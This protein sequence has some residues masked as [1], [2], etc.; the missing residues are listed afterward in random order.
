MN[1]KDNKKRQFIIFG[2]C[3]FAALVLC[4][5][6]LVI[7]VSQVEN[8]NKAETAQ[9]EIISRTQLSGET[10]ELSRYISDL[11]EYTHNNKFVKINSYTD[12]YVDDGKIVVTD[13]DGN[14]NSKDK[15]IFVY[16]KNQI[17]GS[18][19]G[20]YGEDF[21]GEFGTVCEDMPKLNFLSHQGVVSD[22]SVG[23]KD[24][25][26]NTV[27]DD[28]GNIT[29]EE[30]YYITFKINGG[31]IADSK[32]SE[33]FGQNNTPD[34]EKFLK[35]ELSSVLKIASSSVECGEFSVCVKADRETDEISQVKI[36]R[37]YN[38]NADVQ[39]LGKLS[40]FGKKNISFEYKVEEVYDYFYAGIS[41]VEDEVTMGSDDEVMLNVNA[42][43][44]DDSEYKVTFTSSDESIATVDE[45]GYVKCQ[46]ESKEPVVIT[47][48][49]EYLGQTF[50]DQC[51]VNIE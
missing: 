3:S 45:M 11:A 4:M 36:T 39:F 5:I 6:T 28:D 9:E 33:S 27:Y 32:G 22:F 14:E 8:G 43:I 49:L 31:E 18:I 17:L 42:V 41:F 1:K 47:V 40:V 23:L 29:D 2:L 19:D 48:E 51:V 16:F 46:K 34:I 20:L 37:T 12:V 7:T 21:V 25:N 10:G 50:T 44:E 38:V 13:A 24:E 35:E 26:G 30:F 15:D